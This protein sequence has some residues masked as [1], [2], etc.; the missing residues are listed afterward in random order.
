MYV[1]KDITTSRA[2]IQYLVCA[3][4]S[5][6]LRLSPDRVVR[7]RALAGETLCCV[8]GQET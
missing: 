5:W 4:A 6:L 3:V 8:I 1:N 7:S 2:I